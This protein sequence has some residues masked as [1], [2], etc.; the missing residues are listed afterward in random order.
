[1]S[2]WYVVSHCH[3]VA[4]HVLHVQQHHA[5]M[6]MFVWLEG[7]QTMRDVWK[8]ASVDTGDMSVMCGVPQRLRLCASNCLETTSVRWLEPS[9]LYNLV[10][11]PFMYFVCFPAAVPFHYGVFGGDTG[12]NVLYSVSCTG[13]PSRLVDCRY[14]LGQGYYSG[15]CYYYQD[16]G[17]RCYGML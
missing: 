15:G 5:A 10:V 17:V 16:A 4:V 1:M 9:L 11:V 7:T 14:S 3:M 12:K 6:V 13:S 8:C 2:E